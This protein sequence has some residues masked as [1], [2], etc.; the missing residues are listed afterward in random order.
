MENAADPALYRPAPPKPEAWLGGLAGAPHWLPAQRLTEQGGEVLLPVELCRWR[1]VARQHTT[2]P[3]VASLGC[4]ALRAERGALASARG[5]VRIDLHE[6]LQAAEAGAPHRLLLGEARLSERLLADFDEL[7]PAFRGWLQAR[8]QSFH[9]A[10]LRALEPRLD[11]PAATLEQRRHAAQALL[12]LDPTHEAACRALMRLAAEAGDPGLAVRLYEKLWRVLEDD[13]DI[14]PSDATTALL[15]DIKLGRI[16]SRP[17]PA[18]PPPPVAPVAASTLRIALQ[19]EAFAVHGVTLEHVHL[20]HGFRHDLI[21]RLVRFREWFVVVEGPAPVAGDQRVRSRY[22][23]GATAYQAGSRISMVLILVDQD[24]G[25]YVWSERVDLTL[26]TSFETQQHVLRRIAVTLNTHISADRLAR[27]AAHPDVPLE[28][29]DSWLRCR[30]MLLGLDPSDWERAF[31]MA[32]EMAQAV[33]NFAPAWCNLAQLD[34][35]AHIIR[36][37]TWR[38]RVREARALGHAKRAAQLDPTDCRNQLCLGWSHMMMG[39]HSIAASHM[40]L[41][42]ELNPGDSMLLMSLALYRSFAGE[43]GAARGLAEESLQSTLVPSRTHWGYEVSIASLRGDDH[44]ALEACDRAEDVILTLQGWRAAA[45]HRLGRQ[46]EAERAA[47]RF[48]EMVSAA[49]HGPEAPTPAI[50]TRWL[51]HLYPIRRPQDWA[52]LRDG[53]AGAGLPT[54]GAA[55]GA[56]QAPGA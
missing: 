9:D 30:H 2:P 5:S 46:A 25:I 35:V 45:L 15:A 10:L 26:D 50:V 53:L 33:P 38:D 43:H 32:Q 12:Q 17:S 56:W 31:G 21:A 7:D 42:L 27:I 4:A 48:V 55:H 24:S 28:G 29:Y 23:I 39:Q 52:R 13:F 20:V 51:L 22:R 36:P 11:S 8:R 37:G 54:D 14:E 34:N 40:G 47:G 19:V 16:P 1:P 49:W 44:A 6:V 41:A 18:L 3:I